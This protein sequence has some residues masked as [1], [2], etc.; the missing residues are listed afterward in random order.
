MTRSTVLGNTAGGNGGAIHNSGTLRLVASRIRFNTALGGGGI[1]N[2]AGTVQLNA[3][4]VTGN[5]PDN[6][7]GVQGC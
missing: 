6:C 3:S 4:A 5:V 7:F 1:Y 2:D